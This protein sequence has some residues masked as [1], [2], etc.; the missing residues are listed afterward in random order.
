MINEKSVVHYSLFTFHL[1]GR[2]PNKFNGKL[3]VKNDKWV[4]CTFIF[5][6]NIFISHYSLFTFH[7]FWV[8]PDR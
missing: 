5:K 8:V 2:V 4:S 7:L 3:T 6:W 1:F